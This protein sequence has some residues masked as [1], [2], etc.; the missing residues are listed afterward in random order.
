MMEML[1]SSRLLRPPVSLKAQ[2]PQI[3]KPAKKDSTPVSVRGANGSVCRHSSNKSS[4]TTIYAAIPKPCSRHRQ[5]WIDPESKNVVR[6]LNLVGRGLGSCTLCRSLSPYRDLEPAPSQSR[7]F[8]RIS[9]T[10]CDLHDPSSKQSLQPVDARD[11][12]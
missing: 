2:L 9:L 11:Q 6:V 8:K 3:N 12:S 1:T 4:L 7:A 5:A 10:N